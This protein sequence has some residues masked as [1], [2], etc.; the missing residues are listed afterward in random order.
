MRPGSAT[1]RRH[2]DSFI[3]L[4]K[5]GLAVCSCKHHRLQQSVKPSNPIDTL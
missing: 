2:E 3:A 5:R 4:R 1:Q